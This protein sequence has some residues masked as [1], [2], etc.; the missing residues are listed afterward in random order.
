MHEN[1]SGTC[2]LMQ[3]KHVIVP[4]HCLWNNVTIMKY[5][6]IQNTNYSR[7]QDKVYEGALSSPVP[8]YIPWCLVSH[9]T[10]CHSWQ[11]ALVWRHMTER[12]R[13]LG[14][15]RRGTSDLRCPSVR[16]CIRLQRESKWSQ[17]I[18]LA[19]SATSKRA[20]N[21]LCYNEAINPRNFLFIPILKVCKAVTIIIGIAYAVVA[22][23]SLIMLCIYKLPN[24]VTQTFAAAIHLL[25]ACKKAL[26]RNKLFEKAQN[27]HHYG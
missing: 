2:I 10:R 7:M 12:R 23:R 5:T 15:L 20:V 8:N 11:P 13:I 14:A 4:G 3:A 19:S 9:P 27:T 22:G 1:W 6:T 17:C 21:D 18:V 26:Y 25:W 16:W 24:P